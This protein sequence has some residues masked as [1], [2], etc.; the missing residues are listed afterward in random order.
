MT[1]KEIILDIL[2]DHG[3]EHPDA[4]AHRLI[5]ALDAHEPQAQSADDFEPGAVAFITVTDE[6]DGSLVL[7][8]ASSRDIQ[9]GDELTPAEKAAHTGMEMLRDSVAAAQQ[10]APR[11]VTPPYLH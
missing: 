2:T 4:L 5:D 1:P 8:F 7:G 11:I 6:G 9:D 10:E 3:D